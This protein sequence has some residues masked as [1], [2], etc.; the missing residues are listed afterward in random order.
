MKKIHQNIQNLF[1][2]W[3]IVS[4]CAGEYYQ[5]ESVSVAKVPNSEYPNRI[6]LNQYPNVLT[7][8]ILEEI[9]QI[10]LQSVEPLRFSY[11]TDD[12]LQHEDEKLQSFGFVKKSEQ[13]GMSLVLT[14][15]VLTNNRLQLKRIETKEQSEIWS[16]VFR[17]C[18]GYLI[19]AESVY[20]SKAEIQFYLLYYQ[21]NTIGN[22]LLHQTEKTMGVHSLG[23]LPD[24]RKLGFAEEIMHQIINQS[25]ENQCEIM[26]LQSSPMGRNIYLRLGFEEDFLMSNYQF[27]I[28][29]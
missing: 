16:D 5:T 9:K 6:W 26:T 13:Y 21:E 25:I 12:C 27:S 19:S 15:K 10:S 14:E 2:L 17:K 23:I 4:N 1:S 8:E 22:L 3:E 20:Q 18:F 11:F 24:F 28:N 29:N 7:N